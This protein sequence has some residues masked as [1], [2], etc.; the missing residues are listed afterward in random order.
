MVNR[1]IYLDFA[2][3]TPV[4]KAA[5]KAME[6]YFAN[7][8]YNPSAIYQPA[9]NVRATVE[10]ARGQV[11]SVLGSKDQEI[12]FT[13]G[14]TE[15]NNLA[16]KGVMD[17]FTDGHMIVSAIEHESVLEPSKKYNTS[18]AR[19]TNKGITDLDD[20]KS[21]VRDNTVLISVMYANNEIGTIQPIKALSELVNAVR[22]QRKSSGDKTPLYLHTDACQAAN[23]LDLQVTRLGVD[24][25][26]LNGGKI[27]GVKQSGCLY[28][29]KS[30]SLKPLINGGGQEMGLRS[31]TENVTALLS[32]ATMLQKV[33]SDRKLQGERQHLMIN[34]LYATL[35]QKLPDIFLNGHPDKRLPNNLNICIPHLDG[36]RLV[37]ELDEAGVLAATGSACTASNDEPSHVL[38]AIG[39]TK[40]EASSSLRLTIGRS[41]TEEDIEKSAGIIVDCVQKMQKLVQ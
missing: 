39:L 41:T 15:A 9:R 17:Q 31:G 38:M 28:K 12:I 4:D 19:V 27:Y 20:V 22:T 18:V 37:L 23:Y 2:A 30:V 21:L 8:F 35:S 6:P 13:A 29:H 36:E 5:L 24:M 1:P 14:G 40:D 7:Q 32:F 11:A 16:V 33:Q 26:T 25:M 3:A 10:K 34:K